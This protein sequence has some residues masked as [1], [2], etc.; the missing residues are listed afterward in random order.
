[1]G[2]I[3]ETQLSG[4]NSCIASLS[5]SNILQ[6]QENK[7]QV[8]HIYMIV[9]MTWDHFRS[10]TTDGQGK[11]SLRQEWFGQFWDY[12]GCERCAHFF[13]FHKY[14]HFSAVVASFWVL[15]TFLS[16]SWGNLRRR[17]WWWAADCRKPLFGQN[18]R[19]EFADRSSQSRLSQATQS[20]NWLEEGTTYSR[21]NPRRKILQKVGHFF[22]KI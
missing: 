14:L 10:E 1:M 2:G 19:Q 18:W 11:F 12:L 21:P 6:D 8:V 17:T 13:I 3:S 7:L 5:Q 15:C 4:P 20:L 9:Q 22:H 16:V